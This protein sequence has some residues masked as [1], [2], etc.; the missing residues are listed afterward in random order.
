MGVWTYWFDN[1]AVN[2]AEN[3]IHAQLNIQ[4]K[5][6]REEEKKDTQYIPMQKKGCNDYIAALIGKDRESY[7]WISSKIC[8]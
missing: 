6:A 3:V 8:S 7:E 5:K 1:A 4:R 2:N